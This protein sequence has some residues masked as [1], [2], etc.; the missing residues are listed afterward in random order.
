MNTAPYRRILRISEYGDP[1][2]D[3]DALIKLS[4][5]TYLDKVSS[6]LL[7][8]QGATDPRVPAGEAIQIKNA[9]DQ[10]KIPAELVIFA[11]EGHGA[12]KRENQ[13]L[14]YG[15]MIR[16]FTE[17]LRGIQTSSRTNDK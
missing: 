5:T 11:D 7:I 9:L 1:D 17:H 6:P 2:K 14:Q 15:H 8:I 4:P 13:V 16:F 3:K 12:Q 10:K